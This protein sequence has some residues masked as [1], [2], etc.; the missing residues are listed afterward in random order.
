MPTIPA[1]VKFTAKPYDVLNAIRNNA[2]ANYQNYV[3]IATASDASIKEIG[4]IIMDYV[5]LQNEFLYALVNRIGLVLLTNKMFENPLR[6]F[7]KGK[8]DFGETIE[9]YW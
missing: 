3:P 2:S 1:K 6:M 8:L 9:I 5:A 4:A 7:K